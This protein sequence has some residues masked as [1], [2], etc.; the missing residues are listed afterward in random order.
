M[1]IPCTM[2]A[3]LWGPEICEIPVRLNAFLHSCR[4]CRKPGHKDRGAL[5]TDNLFT[6]CDGQLFNKI[7]NNI[8]HVLQQFTPDRNRMTLNYNLRT[9]LHNKT[10]IT[11][12]SDLNERKFLTRN[13]Y[14]NYY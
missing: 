5:D 3:T 11:K 6:D 10:L 12:A 4:Y 8:S 7:I 13:L 1:E 14:K 2:G 9:R